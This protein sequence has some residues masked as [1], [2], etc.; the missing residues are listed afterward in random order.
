MA[1]ADTVLFDLGNVL[2]RWDPRHLYRR[3]FHGRPREMEHFLTHVCTSEWN[4]RHDAGERFQDN[5]AALAAHHPWY[6]REIEAFWS[7]WPEMIP[8]EIEG[9]VQL[10]ERLRANG[11]ELHA[12]TNWSAETFPFAVERFGFLDHFGHIVVSGQVKLIKPDP[13]IFHHAAEA[14]GLT[15]ERTLFVDDSAP[16]IAAAERLGFHV[17]H[18]DGPA[19]LEH[20]L[21]GHGLL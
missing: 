10:L 6:A 15:P 3:L 11:V 16:N 9:S 14:C 1:A 19:D 4:Q 17:H 18:F 2:I 8:G 13:A 20:C 21:R 12:L 5:V 7:C